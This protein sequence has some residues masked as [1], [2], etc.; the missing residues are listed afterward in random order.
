MLGVEQVKEIVILINNGWRPY[1]NQPEKFV[2]EDLGCKKHLRGRPAWFV[3]T[4]K[5]MCVSCS[6]K[7][8]LLRPKGF[9]PPLPIK[10]NE[11]ISREIR[12]SPLELVKKKHVL[13]LYEVAYCLNVS[14]QKV[15]TWVKEGKLTA[16]LDYPLRVKAKDVE[17]MMLN[18]DE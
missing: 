2:Y 4:D 18:F 13:Q 5:Y 17:E 12:L 1:N 10:Y 15:Y 11:E 3:K 6:N 7:C 8:T 14:Y 16:L 9:R